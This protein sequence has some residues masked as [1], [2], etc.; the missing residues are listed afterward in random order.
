MDV[1]RIAEAAETSQ[2]GPTFSPEPLQKVAKYMARLHVSGLPRNYELFYQ[3]MFGRDPVL[4]REVMALGANPPQSL[5]DQIGLKH[6][7]I[8]HCGI[9]DEV[10]QKEAARVLKDLTEEIVARISQNQSFSRSLDVLLAS[11]KDETTHASDHLKAEID[12][13]AASAQD[14]LHA[15][16][17]LRRILERGVGMIED[18]ERTAR[19]AKVA[20]LRDRVTTLPNRIA[21]NN[22][23]ETLYG[24]D[25]NPHG[26]ALIVISVD[27][28]RSMAESFGDQAVNRLIRR[29]SAVMRKSI[30]K[31]DFVARTALDE[32]AFLF[33]G[34]NHE[35]ARAIADRLYTSISDNLVFATDDGSESGRLALSIGYAL[36]DDALTGPQL[37]AHA[38]AALLVAR[39][40]RRNPIAG[41]TVGAGHKPRRQSA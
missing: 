14:M 2:G 28:F 23:I 6:R 20:S 4:A 36:T 1:T 35:D 13:F 32:F 27:R 17:E 10:A 15:E 18:A 11:L 39:A 12:F 26:T 34:V 3:A 21:F 5:L 41:H 29:L 22:R 16:N 24:G 9:A 8:G 40:N 38:Q 7:L 30:K 31:N 19:A 25:T 37:L 33:D